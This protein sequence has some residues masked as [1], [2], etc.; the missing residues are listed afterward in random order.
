MFLGLYYIILTLF[1][2][3]NKYLLIGCGIAWT[4]TRLVFGY[5][6]V[7]MKVSEEIIENNLFENLSTNREK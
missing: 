4:K 3:Q 7:C 1:F 2:Y 5:K 6:I